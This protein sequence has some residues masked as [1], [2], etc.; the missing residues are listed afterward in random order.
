MSGRGYRLKPDEGEARGVR[1]GAAGRAASA[2]ERLRAGSGSDLADAIHGARK[3]L[4]K[5]RSLIR[6]VREPLGEEVYRRENDRF[7]DAARMLGDAR[8]AEAKLESLAGLRKHFGNRFPSRWS[9]DFIASIEAE[10][11]RIAAAIAPADLE[12]PA[13]RIEIGGRAAGRW[14]LDGT[15]FGLFESGL[16]RSY[17]RGRDDLELV[18]SD[19]ADDAV[20]EWRKRVKD[21]WYQTRFLSR[22]WPTVLDAYSEEAHELSSILGDHHDLAVIRADVTEREELFG[23][24]AQEQLLQLIADRQ[25]ELVASAI[26]AGH[27]LYAEK[28]GRFADR[29]SA[30]WQAG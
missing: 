17:K 27:R 30:Y 9:R 23:G 29:I 15:G 22:V 26:P 3:D 4:K 20:H 1:R 21:L 11:D 10:R 8:D 25:Q 14:K 13:R 28:P 2:S 12:E 5:L 7:R 6:L 18:A 24:K 16:R 19:P